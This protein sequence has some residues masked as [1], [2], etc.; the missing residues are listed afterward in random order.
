VV[1]GIV[2]VVFAV[3]PFVGVQVPWVLPGTVDVVNSAGT[4]QVL[5]LCF[6]FGGVALGYDLLFGYTGLLSF[7][8]VLYFA[9]GAYV[10]DIALTKW[11]WAL[12]PALALTAG[13]G[14]IL[15]VVLAP[16]ASG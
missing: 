13:V 2:L 4:L 9:E 1:G 5:G 12:F 3:L 6:V 15:A 11:H 10:F 7:G 14:L 16:S 8:Q